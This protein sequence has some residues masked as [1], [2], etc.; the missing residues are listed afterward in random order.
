MLK[1]MRL[2]K[3]YFFNMSYSKLVELEKRRRFIVKFLIIYI[4]VCIFLITVFVNFIYDKFIEFD[5]VRYEVSKIVLLILLFVILRAFYKFS[6]SYFKDYVSDF[7]SEYKDI[8][9]EPFFK[10]LNFKYSKFGH[11][12]ALDI[13]HS[14]FFKGFDTQDG[15]DFVGGNLNDISFCFSDIILS[16]IKYSLFKDIMFGYLFSREKLPK[17][18]GLFYVCEFDKSIKSPIKIT[19]K[20]NLF[21]TRIYMDNYDFNKYFNVYCDDMIFT[22]Y[23]LTPVFM[24]RLLSLSQFAK[25]GIKISFDRHK[26]YIVLNK[27]KD[28]FE[29][30]FLQSVNKKENFIKIRREIFAVLGFVKNI[31]QNNKLF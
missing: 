11:V 8:V 31:R 10:R 4:L 19:S 30:N 15:N 2:N 14:G 20:P 13:M 3:D 6:V 9:L 21:R 25:G 22:N 23:I 16:K 26:V 18:M 5:L 27:G 7:K 29:P 24:Q 12:H 1:K 28:S 17:F